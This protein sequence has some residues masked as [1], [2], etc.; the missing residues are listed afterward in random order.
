[1][2]VLITSQAHSMCKTM[3]PQKKTSITSS[4]II[5]VNSKDLL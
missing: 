5:T 3:K 4:H 2:G 1:M